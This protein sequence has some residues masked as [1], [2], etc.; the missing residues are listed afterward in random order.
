MWRSCS[1]TRYSLP[2]YTLLYYATLGYYF[3]VPTVAA[4]F[5]HDVT[6]AVHLSVLSRGERRIAK[7][8]NVRYTLQ[9]THSFQLLPSPHPAIAPAARSYSLAHHLARTEIERSSEL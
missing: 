2:Y 4:V 1:C 5:Q 9:I 8:T 6:P 3:L 7:R